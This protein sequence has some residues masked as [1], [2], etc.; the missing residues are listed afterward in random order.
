MKLA[1]LIFLCFS[2]IFIQNN[3]PRRF[4][5]DWRVITPLHSMCDDVKKALKVDKCSLPMSEY[6]VPGFRV[7]V[8]FSENKGCEKDPRDWRVPLGTVTSV[9]VHPDEEMLPCTVGLDLSKY[10]RREDGEI[11]GVEHYERREEGTSL[12]LYRGF[13]QTLYLYP[14]SSEEKLRC[15]PLK[16]S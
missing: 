10:E 4:A 16:S 9:V 6:H 15:K 2:A 1:M 3:N 12:D 11:V 13:V 14:A 5:Q 7:I 8:F